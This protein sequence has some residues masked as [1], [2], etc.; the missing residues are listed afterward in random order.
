L[1]GP[2]GIAV[3]PLTHRVYVTGR[4]TGLVAELDPATLWPLRTFAVGDLPFGVSVDAVRNK[5]YVANFGSNNLSVIDLAAGRVVKTISFAPYGQPAFVAYNSIT[6]RVYV[7]LHMGGRLAVIDA[8]DDTLLTTVW[9]GGGAFGVA[10]SES[11][12]R[13]YV[14]CRDARLIRTV[15]GANNSVLWDQ[16]IPIT[17]VPYALAADG[18]RDR[19]YAVVA[20]TPDGFN[21]RQVAVYE[22]K[23]NS[24]AWIGQVSVGNGGSNGGGGIAV[25]PATQHV[26]VSNSQDDTAT[27]LH[28]GTLAQLR[29]IATGADPFPVAVDAGRN[30]AYIGNRGGDTITGVTDAP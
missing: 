13:V 3:H 23:A 2:N 28:G 16:T 24:V 27:V 30:A 12:N 9:V 21:P 26:F 19:L 25:N 18:A 8:A 7:A 22:I 11:L 4:D 10:V 1:G 15:D 14:S 5:A 20:P 29:V 17:G 6:R